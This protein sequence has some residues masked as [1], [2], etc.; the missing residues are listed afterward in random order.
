M[1]TRDPEIRMIKSRRMIWA[2]YVARMWRRGMYIGYWWES[3]KERHHL[4]DQGVGGWILRLIEFDGTDGI[5]L[6][7][8]RD[9]KALVNTVLN[10]RVP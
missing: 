7:E 5:D 8:E 2:G 1:V 6:A 3:Q 4:E 9:Q 10:L